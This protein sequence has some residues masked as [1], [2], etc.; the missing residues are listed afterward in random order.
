M[1][2]AGKARPATREDIE[3]GAQICLHDN[4]FGGGCNPRIVM[5]YR[6]G[7]AETRFGQKEGIV[8]Y[9]PKEKS[10]TWSSWKTFDEGA[11]SIYM[12]HE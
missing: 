12:V 2:L 7:P 9:R 3:P 4:T 1:K 6:S 11:R 5:C 10:Y 8:L